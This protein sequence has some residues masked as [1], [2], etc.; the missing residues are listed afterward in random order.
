MAGRG[1]PRNPEHLV[2]VAHVLQPQQMLEDWRLQTLLPA[3]QDTGEAI[4]WL[5]IRWLATRGLL[6]NTQLCHV[7]GQNMTVGTFNGHLDGKRWRCPGACNITKT[8][9]DGSWFEKSKLS[10][11]TSILLLYFWS[12]DFP[13]GLVSRELQL[14]RPTIIDWSNFIREVCE[15][16]LRLH[17]QQVGG[18]DEATGQPIIVEIDESKY[19]HRKYHRGQWRDGHWVFGGIER[20]SG[21][22]FMVEVP[23]R[24]RATLEPIV[25]QYILPGSHIISDGWRA[26]GNLAQVGGGIYLHDVIVH[27]QHF[28]DPNNPT[29]HTN[30]IENTWM[31]AKRKLKRQFGTSEVLFPSYLAEFLWRSRY[32]ND[33]QYYFSHLLTCIREQY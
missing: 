12:A 23:D 1:R 30:N 10:L 29:I 31:R 33:Q 15:E 25:L 26:Y 14:S 8:I 27:D 7:C 6:K 9:R 18:L 20:D 21:K 32:R 28:V 13:Q 19:F 3:T 11:P 22:C 17:P 24:S 4:R 2:P 5:A 16:D